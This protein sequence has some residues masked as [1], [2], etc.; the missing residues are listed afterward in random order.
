MKYYNSGNILSRPL[1]K[2]EYEELWSDTWTDRLAHTFQ[3]RFLF[4]NC[5]VN[6]HNG[7]GLERRPWRYLMA[8]D[9]IKTKDNKELIHNS[10]ESTTSGYSL[11]Y[12]LGENPMSALD[13]NFE[14]LHSQVISMPGRYILIPVLNRPKSATTVFYSVYIHRINHI[15]SRLWCKQHQ[16]NIN[17]NY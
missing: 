7:R 4:M 11:F 9:T 14:V 17:N 13:V 8:F 15:V 2:S 3:Q 10:R 16:I 1:A 6:S 5:I 12:G